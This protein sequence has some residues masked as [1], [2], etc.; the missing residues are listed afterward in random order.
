M[1]IDEPKCGCEC[2]RNGIKFVRTSLPPQPCCNCLALD[3]L[4]IPEQIKT[5]EESVNKIQT[6][7]KKIIDDNQIYCMKLKIKMNDDYER[8][9]RQI[10]ENRKVSRRMDELE[11]KI[12]KL[13]RLIMPQINGINARIRSL[14]I[15]D[16]NNNKKPHKC[17]VC[18]GT[19]HCSSESGLSWQCESCEGKGIVWG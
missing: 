2:H 10:D 18:E 4:S 6:L 12:H 15:T 1:N 11:Y 19:R 3:G 14:E 8:H 17:P 13:D 9:V 16:E 7:F 5:L